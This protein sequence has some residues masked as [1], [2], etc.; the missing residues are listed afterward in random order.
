MK[1]KSLLLFCFFSAL[2]VLP[3]F[4]GFQTSLDSL[5][6][7]YENVYG[8]EKLETLLE[9][10]KVYWEI[11]PREGIAKGLQ[12]LALAQSLEYDN[13]IIKAM[14]Y[15]GTAYYIDNQYDNSLD[16]LLKAYRFAQDHKLLKDMADISRQLA[17]VYYQS[18]KYS[19]T[20]TYTL[21]AKK[22]YENIDDK[23]GIASCL[24]LLG[25]YYKA[26]DRHDQALDYLQE[27]LALGKKMAHRVIVGDALNDIGSLYTEMGDTL[28]AIRTYREAVDYYKS[29][30]PNNK[31]GL[32]ELNMSELYLDHGE[33]EKAK[34][35]LDK[36]Y[37]I[38]SHLNSKRLFR[39]YYK[40]LSLYYTKLGNY[41]KSVLAHQNLQAYQDS[42]ASEQLSNKIDDLDSR[43][44]EDVK[45]QENQLL[46]D[47]NQT[48]QLEIN[49]QYTVGLLILLVLLVVIFLLTFRYR[50]NLKDNELLYLRNRLVSQHQEELIGAMKRLKDSEDK[51]RTAN[52][53]KDK[54]FSLIAH[55]LRGS[56]GNI[57]NGLRMMLTDKELNLSEED[58]TEF[59]VSLFHSADNSFELLEN[60]LFWA[61]NQTSTISAN[62]QM[63]DASSIINSNIGLLAELAKIKSIKLFTSSNAS[64]EVYVD[65]NMI[66]T[67]LRNLISNAIKFTHKEG[68]I[69]IKS[70]IGEYFVKISVIDNGI[71]MMPEQIENI[72]EGKTTDGTANEKGTGLGITLCRDFLVK[73]HGQMMVESEVDKGSTFSFIIPRRPMGNDKYLEFVEK[74][75]LLS[76]VNN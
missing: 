13:E 35:H 33:L 71:G 61:K 75:S 58:K 27:A 41:K 20:Y 14:Y 64:V 46:R 25:L 12:A 32:F 38:A 9:M 55:D 43:H 63:V 45:N 59:L 68:S 50:N 40:Y 53:T 56:I 69:E 52:K 2:L 19:K 5:N 76:L 22:I 42:I 4:A 73:N 15:V 18:G 37:L 54:M 60:L 16:Y 11:E 67:V 70:E 30:V 23:V 7:R 47:E 6:K 44:I 26:I 65:W 3:T 36:G 17:T 66:N 72:Y 74:E 39:G 21:E 10:S 8:Q 62:L 57:S 49:R 34:H 31:I 51:L 1:K 28:K 24:N 48:Q 29:K